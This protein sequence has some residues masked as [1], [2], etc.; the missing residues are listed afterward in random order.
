LL[1]VDDL[2]DHHHPTIGSQGSRANGGFAV[3]K[4]GGRA[5]MT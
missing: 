4:N 3:S 5:G 2:N 1:E